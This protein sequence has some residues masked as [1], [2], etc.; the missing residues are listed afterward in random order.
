MNKNS[1][2]FCLGLSLLI[3]ACQ[4]VSDYTTDAA[5]I[6]KGQQ[7]FELQCSSCHNFTSSGIGPNLAGVT[8]QVSAEWLKNFVTN[9]AAMIDG[10]DERAVQLHQEYKTYMPAFGTLAEADL[11]AILGYLHTQEAGAIAVG[12][13]DLGP[14]LENPIPDTVPMSDLVLQ[15]RQVAHAPQTQE[16]SPLARINKM[17]PMAGDLSREFVHDL[18]GVLYEL[19]KGELI[20]FLKISEF[21]PEFIN[22]PGL[23]TGLGSYAFHPDFQ[24]NGI[25]YTDHTED[26]ATAAPAEF[27]FSDTIPRKVRW[28][29]TEWKMDDPKAKTFSGTH[30]ELM[31]VDMV[32]QIHGMQD[33]EFNPQAKPGDPDYGMLYIGIGDGGSVE[34]RYAFLVQNK[35]RIWG[36]ILRIDP[37]GNNSKNGHYGIPPDNPFAGEMADGALGEIWAMGFRNPHRMMWDAGGDG[38]MLASDIGH[39]MIEELNQ[40]EK[41]RNYGWPEREGTF[42][43]D[44]LGKLDHVYAL[45]DNDADMGITYPVLQ[46]DHDE[47][48]AISNGYV[49]YGSKL[50]ELNGKYFFGGIVNGRV[51]VAT[52]ADFHLGSQ[53]AFQEVRL[54]LE[55]SPIATLREITGN[56]RVDLRFGFD[57]QG[58]MYILTK[59]DGKIYQIAGLSK[60]A[61]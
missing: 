4:T 7:I 28:V 43:F 6:A 35:S 32:T 31:R 36:N 23:A 26:P 38:K 50:P 12:A 33:L 19:K 22:Q 44:K 17:V 60:Q 55:G 51:F 58:E 46:F 1:I 48:G 61:I 53:A 9:P 11:E 27:T 45:P 2:W 39:H 52:A 54:Q 56:K 57:G 59:A 13:A 10:G 14:I 47:A 29:L 21:F 18:N 16:K 24:T 49:Y 37:M 42:R 8:D 15:L 25:F 5:A 3:F 41:G 20:P 30:R 40:I 34:N